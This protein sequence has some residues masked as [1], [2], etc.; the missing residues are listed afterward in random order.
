MISIARQGARLA[1]LAV[2][3]AA[4]L[5]ATAADA[6]D[7]S[8]SE[9][10]AQYYGSPPPQNYAPPPG[11]PPPNYPPPYGQ[12]QP[13]A[14]GQPAPPPYGGQPGP[15]YPPPGREGG[16]GG[17]SIHISDATYAADPRTHCDATGAVRN[18]CEDRRFCEVQS[19][20][21]L[22]GDPARGR[23]KTLIIGYKCGGGRREIRV[24]QDQT[25]RLHC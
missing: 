17:D 16:G 24:P 8:H 15:G 6:G 9:L 12:A 25:A 23:R 14:Y 5:A 1:A 11:N 21:R 19:D 2:I 20:D 4:G 10:L 7:S 3:A 22:C 18:R 13:P